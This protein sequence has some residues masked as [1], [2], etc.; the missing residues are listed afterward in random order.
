MAVQTERR[1]LE[2]VPPFLSKTK[3]VQLLSFQIPSVIR[4]QKLDRRLERVR[5]SELEETYS[6]LAQ[7]LIDKDYRLDWFV[8][9]VFA[10]AEVEEFLS[11]VRYTMLDCLR[12]SY[13]RVRQDL[14]LIHGFR[15]DL[16]GTLAMSYHIAVLDCPLETDAY[17]PS[18]GA[19][20]PVWLSAP[21]LITEFGEQYRTILLDHALAQYKV[22]SGAEANR[23]L[24]LSDLQ[25]V[26]D[27]LNRTSPDQEYDATLEVQGQ[28]GVVR[29]RFQKKNL[30]RLRY[31]IAK[32]LL[33]FI[34]AVCLTVVVVIWVCLKGVWAILF[35]LGIVALAILSSMWS[36]LQKLRF[37]VSEYERQRA[38]RLTAP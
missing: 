17:P 11:V 13:V 14:A 18:G 36:T 4:Q 16:D 1:I 3:Q 8:K 7:G 33:K 15:P 37:E 24:V 27:Q 31:S 22:E 2:C 5:A 9:E 20:L 23:Q 6:V 10:E 25:A 29:I 19:Q 28:G 34:F 38:T 21:R 30:L 12:H 35:Y 32:Q 26:V